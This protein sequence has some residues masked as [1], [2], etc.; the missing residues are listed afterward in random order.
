[1][2]AETLFRLE[3][4]FAEQMERTS[5]QYKRWTQLATLLAA[6]VM[7]GAFDLDSVR[8]SSELYRNS[9]L[10]AAVAD[11]VA[12]QVQ[13]KKTFE[14]VE[15]SLKPFAELPI[16]WTAEHTRSR[17][18]LTAVIGWLLSVLALSLG[19]PFWFDLVGKFVNLRQTGRQPARDQFVAQ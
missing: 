6:V 9:T 1:M 18:W 5:G 2:D 4:W 11:Q 19:A 16:G 14:D 8:I 13:E 12:A 7:T 17:N 10:R 15:A 3:K